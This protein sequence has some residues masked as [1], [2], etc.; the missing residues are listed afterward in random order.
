VLIVAL[1]GW[2][3]SRHFGQRAGLVGAAA[4]ALCPMALGTARQLTTDATLTLCI[5][6]ALICF[7]SGDTSPP[8]K[9]SRW[10]YGFWA[11]CAF[12]V[13]AKGAPGIIIPVLVALLFV[14]FDKGFRFR[15]IVKSVIEARPL[16]GFLL[17]LL[18]TL[19]WHVAAYRASGE[20]FTAEYIIR[21]HIGRFRGGDTS[22]LA[23]FWFFLPGFL[24]G[25]FPW[26]LFVPAALLDKKASGRDTSG[27][28][29]LLLLK[30][31]AVT[32]FVMF[33]ASG[34]KLISYIL[35][36]YPAAA[37]LV[38]GWCSRA[39]DR[40]AARRTLAWCG[41]TG[42]VMTAFLTAAVLFH[43]PIIQL[44]EQQ[45]RRPVKMDDVPPELIA[46]AG[47]L[48]LAAAFGMG[49]FLLL[50]F[51]N[52]RKHAFG[53]LAGGMALFIAVGVIEGLPIVDRAFFAPLHT[54]AARGAEEA[55]RRNAPLILFI[56]PP[57]RPSALFYLP[58]PALRSAVPEVMKDE[59]IDTALTAA[60][61]SVVLTHNKRAAA[62]AATGDCQT[63][64]ANGVWTLLECR[65]PS[66]PP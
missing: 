30:V 57:R 52:H 17:F 59:D 48:F 11:A 25:F 24:A 7:F 2:F 32:V 55:A 49:L 14:G 65:A 38:G 37:L 42:F 10:Y 63:I 60:P 22:H 19:P 61:R 46:W 1:I 18:I 4:Y 27:G 54:L 29:A 35:P 9:K 34:S 21:Q 33:S 40:P 66:S 8:D 13:L 26:S 47:H 28:R 50:I 51:L 56:G 44:I 20:A 6:A 58:D 5:S 16:T 12:G 3:G 41:A 15:E 23:P 36:M 45:S 64:A 62:L 31:W 43:R 53:A 39:L